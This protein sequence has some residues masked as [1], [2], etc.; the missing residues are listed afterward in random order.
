[1]RQ[2]LAARCS[3]RRPSLSLVGGMLGL[4]F[5]ALFF[6]LLAA[7]GNPIL[8]GIG[9]GLI[10]GPVLLMAPRLTIWVILSVGL[11]GGILSASP[12]F[13]KVTWVISILSF[14]LMLPALVTMVWD[15]RQRVPGFLWLAV[16]FLLA[17][18]ATT[19]VTWHSFGEFLAGFKRY[20]QSFGLMLALAM[21]TFTPASYRRWRGFLVVVALLQTPAALYELLVLVPQRGGLGLSSETTDV[22]AG[23][24]GAN[25]KGGSPNSVM[26]AYLFVVLAF[27]ASR[28]R[29]GLLAGRSYWPLAFACLLPL[30]MGETK[31]AVVMLPTVALV[32]MRHDI[33][34]SPM[35][36]LPGVIAV[37][38]L[39]TLL[40][41]FYIAF[42]MQT[43][44]DEVLKSVIRYNVGDQGYSKGQLLN[45]T[46]VIT[47]WLQQHG[48]R[49]PLGFLIG[50]G[51]G[52]SYTSPT[53]LGGHI[54]AKYPFY[55]INLTAVSTILW[56]TGILGL[57][58]FAS[59]FAAAWR[60]AGQLFTH[61]PNPQV[62]AD[63]L[64]CQA[65]IALFAML[66]LYSDTM[67]NLVSMELIYAAVLGYLGYLLQGGFAASEKRGAAHA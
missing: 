8:I 28:W 58:L 36:Y 57:A 52:S 39:T 47:F 17:S 30:A 16:A 60:A 2:N 33:V 49:D 51:L 7:L 63:A 35:R 65:A 25:L 19:L 14:L 54:G 61:S 67:V 24:F 50:H 21:L 38:L 9:A 12:Q 40:G 64:A 42:M 48:L 10:L 34:R 45:R 15:K 6:G 56:D 46:T 53:E 23:T 32:L 59:I 66:L 1:M 55:G 3:M 11:V 31:I 20:F 43:S 44:L 37:L 5:A 27:L 29:A 18:C 26:V 62:R 13:G 4:G 41:Y 22:I